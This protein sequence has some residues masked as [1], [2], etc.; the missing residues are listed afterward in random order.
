M[1]GFEIHRPIVR[2]H[3]TP[4][5]VGMCGAKKVEIDDGACIS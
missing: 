3:K 5:G 1:L 4:E 2:R